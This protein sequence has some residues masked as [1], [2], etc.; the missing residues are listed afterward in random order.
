MT[1]TT[2]VVPYGYCHCGCG[3][4]TKI[5]K[6]AASARPYLVKGEPRKF[7]AGHN[8]VKVRQEPPNP[9]GF[10]QCGC[11]GIAPIATRT[12][13]GWNIVK[14]HPKRF[15]SG[16]QLK[17]AL[18]TR[19]KDKGSLEERFWAKVNKN[20][21]IHRYKP[22]LGPCWLWTA[23][24]DTK[25]YGVFGKTSDDTVFAHRFAY[26]LKYGP[27][28]LYVLHSCDVPNCVNDA[29]LFDGTQQ[30]NINDMMSKG[31]G[32]NQ[33]SRTQQTT[34]EPILIGGNK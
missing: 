24:L 2:Q 14:G 3:Q 11:G 20:G 29:H 18:E 23:A 5:V 16:H 31:R 8:R 4:K 32:A 25:G 7:V 33:F 15:I 34:V 12:D 6:S 19:Y 21:P 9:S 17:T 22:E 10:C 13:A 28:E 26:E 1:T 30:D 27:T